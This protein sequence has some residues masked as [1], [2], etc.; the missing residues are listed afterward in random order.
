MFSSH[1]KSQ[2]ADA[3]QVGRL[4][5]QPF[6]ERH[7]LR[8]CMVAPT[9]IIAG[10]GMSIGIHV[11]HVPGATGPLPGTYA[12]RPSCSS[13]KGV[14]SDSMMA[15]AFAPIPVCVFW[16]SLDVLAGFML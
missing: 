14:P 10:L 1:L 15:F 13:V 16:S 8:A 12:L 7:N 2:V 9:K 3:W 6:S 11:L 4:A 5:V